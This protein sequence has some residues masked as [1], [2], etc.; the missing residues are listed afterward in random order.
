MPQDDVW[1]VRRLV[2]WTTGFFAEKGCVSPR[3]EAEVL[4][5]QAMKFAN[6]PEVYMKY[7]YVPTD[8]ERAAFRALVKRRASGEPT[9]Y[10]V[11]KKEF[12]SL[13]FDVDANVLVPRPETEDLVEMTER[14]LKNRASKDPAAPEIWRVCDLCTGS[15]CVAIALAK[16][17][18]KARLTALDVS[19]EALE[20]ARRNVAKHKLEERVEL[21]ESDLFAALDPDVKFDFI[22]GNPP[23]VSAAEYDALEP[24]VR[25]FEPKLA[26]LGGQT[27]AEIALRIVADA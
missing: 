22:V 26:L 15:G 8:A 21:I 19:P 10:L 7:D 5:V 1:T 6:R 3:V 9:A 25:D 23:Y 18:P 14:F 12:Y 20:V 27:G 11:G 2:E 4:A 16:Q 13:E 17:L 24:T